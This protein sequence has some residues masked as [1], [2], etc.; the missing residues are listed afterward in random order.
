MKFETLLFDVVDGVARVTLNRPT[1]ANAMNPQMAAEIA[2]LAVICDDDPAIRAVLITGAGRFFCAGGDLGVFA[3]AGDSSRSLLKKMAGDLH[4]GLSRLA[5]G[6]APVIAAVNGT[7]AGAG[8]SLVVACDLA[9]AGESTAFTMA[10]TRA[11]LA[12]DGGSTFFMPRRIGDRRTRELMLTNRVLNATEALEWGVVN[13]VVPDAELVDRA[14]TLARELAAGPTLA[15]GAVKTLLSGS[16]E[17]SLETQMELEARSIAE[18]SVSDDG[19]EGIA[20]FL[21]KRHAQF[22]GT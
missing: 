14:E 5:R 12:P 9:V 22:K 15:Y 3:A 18:L 10:Y 11:G 20:A 2:E 4:M 1:A 21:E 13:Q 8:L 6:H 17:Q 19:R 16:F 7:A